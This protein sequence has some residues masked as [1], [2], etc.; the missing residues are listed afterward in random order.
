MPTAVMCTR[1]S[2]EPTKLLVCYRYAHEMVARPCDSSDNDQSSLRCC[3]W[4]KLE[5]KDVG[6]AS[7]RGVV[8]ME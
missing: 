7:H 6:A 8:M 4:G 5:P 3:S 1:V 2:A